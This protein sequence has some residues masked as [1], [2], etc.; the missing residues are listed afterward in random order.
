MKK[1]ISLILV[2]CMLL[3]LCACGNSDEID[4]YKKEI[5]ELKKKVETLENELGVSYDD[6]VS[7]GGEQSGDDIIDS[8]GRAITTGETI[9]IDDVIEF[10]L[11][12]CEIVEEV[13]PSTPDGVYTHYPDNEGEKYIVLWGTVTN[14]NSNSYD[15]GYIIE[16]EI[17]ING[18]YTFSGQVESEES[19]GSCFNYSVLPLQTTKFVIFYSVSDKAAEILSNGT[20]TLYVANNPDTAGDYFDADNDPHNVYKLDI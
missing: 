7:D 6:L 5:K 13:N 12:Y 10:T 19:D 4:E 18:Q 17:T 1:L 11:D 15:I 16:S 3:C 14:L 9:V 8:N 2:A 20:C